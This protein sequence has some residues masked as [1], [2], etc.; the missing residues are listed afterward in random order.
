MLLIQRK[1]T[2][3]FSETRLSLNILEHIELGYIDHLHDEEI[4]LNLAYLGDIFLSKMKRNE[5]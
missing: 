3:T 1:G 5:L 4:V 2:N